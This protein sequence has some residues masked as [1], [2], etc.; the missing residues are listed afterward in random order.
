[1]RGTPVTAWL[2][3]AKIVTPFARSGPLFCTVI[4]ERRRVP[5]IDKSG[6][7]CPLA[8]DTSNRQAQRRSQLRHERIVAAVV[9]IR[10]VHSRRRN[11]FFL[12]LQGGRIGISGEVWVL[13]HV[14]RHARAFRE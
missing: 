3:L 6:L 10:R 12:H 2:R 7:R 9:S 4:G 5:C 13:V 1:M 8:Q 11:Q 14:E